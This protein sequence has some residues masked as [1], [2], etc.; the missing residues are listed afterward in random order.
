M[1]IMWTFGLGLSIASIVVAL[2][3]GRL[4]IPHLYLVA[5]CVGTFGI[6]YELAEL[7]ALAHVA[8]KSQL[9]AAVAQNE[10]VYTTVS[11]LAPSLSGLLFRVGRLFPF[12]AD[13]ISR[14]VLF[15]SLLRIL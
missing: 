9:P 11:L 7:G 10:A 12:V 2:A 14:L 5:L 3:M 8:S 13:V 4:T 15:V 1:M 6:F